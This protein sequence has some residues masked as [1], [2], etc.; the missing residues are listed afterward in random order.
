VREELKQRIWLESKK[1]MKARDVPSPDEADALA[2]TFAQPV[3]ARVEPPVG[4][5]RASGSSSWMG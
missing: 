2:L 5:L 1:E 3:A 4:G